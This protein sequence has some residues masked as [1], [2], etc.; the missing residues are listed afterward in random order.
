MSEDT[1]ES[2]AAISRATAATE[3]TDCHLFRIEPAQLPAAEANVPLRERIIVRFRDAVAELP[4][5]TPMSAAA[6]PLKA[7]SHP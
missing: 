3:T 4:A 7:V 5:S 1:D 6:E 2:I